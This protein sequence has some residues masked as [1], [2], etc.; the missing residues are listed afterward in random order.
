[1]AWLRQVSTALTEFSDIF[2]LL[3]RQYLYK[4]LLN[5]PLSQHFS[6]STF[7]F[8]LLPFD[9]PSCK[10]IRLFLILKRNSGLII[11]LL[12]LTDM[13]PPDKNII[14]ISSPLNSPPTPTT[15]FSDMP[16]SPP[17]AMPFPLSAVQ[18]EHGFSTAPSAMSHFSTSTDFP[19]PLSSS[20]LDFESLQN[21]E[22]TTIAEGVGG[23]SFSVVP[24]PLECLHE[25]PVPPFLSKTFDLVDDAALDSIIAW[26][27][28]G[29]S[30][31]VWDPVEFSRTILPRN[32]KHNNFSSFVRQLNTYVGIL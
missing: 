26:G 22:D 29:N 5:F 30:F 31:V 23:E 9:E 17:Y 25:T 18:F 13:N 14:P 12:L 21:F 28:S 8:L 7:F 16:P 1:M 4:P 15:Q 3:C 6:I 32:F 20:F 2:K 10:I 27:N 11:F 24:Q 19:L